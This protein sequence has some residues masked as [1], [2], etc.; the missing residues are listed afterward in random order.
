LILGSRPN[1]RAL[2]QHG[3]L[4]SLA[5]DKLGVVHET[6]QGATPG[7]NIAEGRESGPSA[8]LRYTP[9]REAE[10]CGPRKGALAGT[11]GL[12]PSKELALLP[13]LKFLGFR[14]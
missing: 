11:Q 1:V 14:P 10:G 2:P 4:E 3:P 7:S 12:Q 13:G 9:G 6:G 5:A 8:R